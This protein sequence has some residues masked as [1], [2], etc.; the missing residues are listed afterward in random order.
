MYPSFMFYFR[1]GIFSNNFGCSPDETVMFKY[2]LNK[3]NVSNILLMIQPALD[4]YIIDRFIIHLFSFIFTSFSPFNV[5]NYSEEPQPVFLSSTSLKEDC[6]LLLDTF[7][8]VI[9]WHGKTIVEWKKCGYHEQEEYQNLKELLEIPRIDAESICSKRFPYPLL[10]ECNA[11]TGP[12]RYLEAVVDPAVVGE[13]NSEDAS[14]KSF[15]D[16]LKRVIVKK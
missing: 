3:E 9:V 14:L 1:R 15:L 16:Q 13:I 4:Q 12:A 2:Y 11:K 10:I 6:V 7:F 8:T 5:N